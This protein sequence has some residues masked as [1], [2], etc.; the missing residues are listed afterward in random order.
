MLPPQEL[1]QQVFICVRSNLLHAFLLKSSFQTTEKPLCSIAG[2]D[3]SHPTDLVGAR[4]FLLFVIDTPA[5]V[6][7]V[8]LGQPS[9]SSVSI[10]EN[11]RAGQHES[12]HVVAKSLPSCLESPTADICQHSSDLPGE[13]P[14]CP[15]SRLSAVCLSRS[16]REPVFCR[17]ESRQW[18]RDCQSHQA[19]FVVYIALA[20]SSASDT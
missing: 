4:K 2:Y 5:H 11:Q 16:L 17:H 12:E 18:R 3:L 9:V 15:G 8:C 19:S 7:G 13:L 10:C 1:S 14:P 20:R 6:A